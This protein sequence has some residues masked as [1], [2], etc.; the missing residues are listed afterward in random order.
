MLRLLICLPES[1]TENCAKQEVEI[2]AYDE[3]KAKN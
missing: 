2:K 1:K 3:V